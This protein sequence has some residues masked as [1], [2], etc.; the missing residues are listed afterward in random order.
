MVAQRGSGDPPEPLLEK[1]ILA[2]VRRA[3]RWT[4]PR[5]GWAGTARY[6]GVERTA[7]DGVTLIGRVRLNGGRGGR[8]GG[9]GIA[10]SR[11][12]G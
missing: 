1:Q 9:E 4:W 7:A 11:R 12:V 6:S 8:G 2:V 3:R 10:H 5:R